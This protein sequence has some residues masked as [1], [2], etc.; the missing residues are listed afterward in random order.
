MLRAHAHLFPFARR[1]RRRRRRRKQPRRRVAA[2]ATMR[3]NLVMLRISA[4]ARASVRNVRSVRR[5]VE[6]ANCT[7]AAMAAESP[8]VAFFFF[9]F[10][11]KKLP[12]EASADARALLPHFSSRSA[13]LSF[14]LG[15]FFAPLTRAHRLETSRL[16]SAHIDGARA[17]VRT[18]FA[19]SSGWPTDGRLEFFVVVAA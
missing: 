2:K 14:V 5:I 9:F 3:R 7:D 12:S 10:Y 1:C 4:R 17:R 8:L 13:R 19:S 18:L 15:D 11:S 16:P 6:C